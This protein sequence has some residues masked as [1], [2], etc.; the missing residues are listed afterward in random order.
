LE[1]EDGLPNKIA[2]ILR[3]YPYFEKIEINDDTLNF[4]NDANPIVEQYHVPPGNLQFQQIAQAVFNL[5][6]PLNE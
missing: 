3:E 5:I 4:T 2:D 1:G 6:P